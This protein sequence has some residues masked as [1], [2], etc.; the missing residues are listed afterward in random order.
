[1]GRP[2]STKP[3]ACRRSHDNGKGS[4]NHRKFVADGEYRIVVKALKAEG[5]AANPD[6]W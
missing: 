2:A 5:E 6:H 3:R 4:P 1:M